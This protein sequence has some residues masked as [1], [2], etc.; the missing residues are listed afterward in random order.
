ML[1]IISFSEDVYKT[2]VLEEG[3]NLLAQAEKNPPAHN[4]AG[5][6]QIVEVITVWLGQKAGK[7]DRVLAFLVTFP[8]FA[9]TAVM[10]IFKMKIGQKMADTS[11]ELTLDRVR[12]AVEG[13]LV[14]S[15]DT[16]FKTDKAADGTM[17]PLHVGALHNVLNCFEIL[18]KGNFETIYEAGVNIG[19]AAKMRFGFVLESYEDRIDAIEVRAGKGGQ[20]A[21]AKPTTG[22]P[23][24]KTNGRHAAT[25]HQE[26]AGEFRDKLSIALG[27]RPA[28]K[29]A[30]QVVGQPDDPT[31]APSTLVVAENAE[32]ADMMA[33]EMARLAGLSPEALDLAKVG[34]DGGVEIHTAET[35]T[36]LR[37]LSAE[38][39]T[40][41]QTASVEEYLAD[42]PTEPEPEQEIALAT[43]EEI[44]EAMAMGEPVVIQATEPELVLQ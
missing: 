11:R 43:A 34:G 24:G 19:K 14:Y 13:V 3:E 4:T 39:A 44:A 2:V 31:S 12:P 18:E 36:L 35:Q 23:N 22:K 6:G 38:A 9:V 7:Q 17:L 25:V 41:E 32:P 26:P 27:I 16:L 42:V 37:E 33:A 8:Q 28:E 20:R 10:N 5:F 30:E 1:N 21:S 15:S 29:T 40:E